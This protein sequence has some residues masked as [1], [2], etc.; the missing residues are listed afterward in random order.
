MSEKTAKDP[1][2]LI[3]NDSATLFLS[4]SLFRPRRQGAILYGRRGIVLLQVRAANA[5]RSEVRQAQSAAWSAGRSPFR[6]ARCSF[7]PS[8][9]CLL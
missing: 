4:Q 3:V 7:H 5:K 6:S 2:D 8:L 9:H 1:Y